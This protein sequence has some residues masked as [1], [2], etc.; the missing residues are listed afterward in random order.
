M[1]PL[2][3]SRIAFA[4]KLD[5]AGGLPVVVTHLASGR[6]NAE[7]RAKEIEALLE[8]TRELGSPHIVMGDF[9]AKPA[10]GASQEGVARYE[11]SA[12]SDRS[13]VGLHFTDRPASRTAGAQ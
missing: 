1:T 2:P 4:L 13:A 12:M 5:S 6:K 10:S 3:M 9:N 8:R 7:A 11:N